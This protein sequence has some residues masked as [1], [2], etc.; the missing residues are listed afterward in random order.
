MHFIL[1]SPLIRLK[2]FLGDVLALL[3]RSHKS[4]PEV[5]RQIKYDADSL[6]ISLAIYD[7]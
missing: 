4:S 3:A 6:Y 2:S 5:I 1:R 7:F